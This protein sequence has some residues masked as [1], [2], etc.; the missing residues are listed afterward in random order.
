MR[1]RNSIIKH[2]KKLTKSLIIGIDIEKNNIIIANQLL[3][4]SNLRNVNFIHGDI[5]NQ[6]DIADYVIL[7]T[8]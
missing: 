7:Q 8:F 3:N 4:K 6:N 1:N 5:N 2:S